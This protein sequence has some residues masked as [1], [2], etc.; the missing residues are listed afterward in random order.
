MTH[1]G[2]AKF[3]SMLLAEEDKLLD[4]A[5][6]EEFPVDKAISNYSLNFQSVEPGSCLRA[7]LLASFC[8][9]LIFYLDNKYGECCSLSSTVEHRMGIMIGYIECMQNE[10]LTDEAADKFMSRLNRLT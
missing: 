10:S 5:K 2:K 1:K 8:G 9:A 3:V 7:Y 6:K 4:F